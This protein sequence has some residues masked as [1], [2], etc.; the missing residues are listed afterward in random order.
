MKKKWST[1]Q[2]IG[3]SIGGAVLAMVLLMSF[4][5]SVYQLFDRITSL[6]TTRAQ[7]QE[8]EWD[9]E[10]DEDDLLP[11]DWWDQEEYYEFQ[12]DIKQD[13]SYSVTFEDF[14]YTSPENDNCEI[15]FSYPLVSGD[16]VPNIDGVN[17]AI[18]EELTVVQEYVDDNASGLLEEET[19]EFE[20]ECYVTYMEE[21]I[22]SIIYV[23]TGYY[24]NEA[25]EFY[26][27]SLNFDMETGMIMSNTQL[28]DIDDD[29]SIEFR[30][31][32]EKQN[33]EFD[34]ISMM[35]DQEITAYL[36]NSDQIII[37]YTPMGME[38]GFNYYEGW[39][40]VTYTDYLKFQQKL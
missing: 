5:I 12:D 23:E 33:G 19:F 18:Q 10:Q 7:S 34:T 29:F 9:E 37:F 6:K 38:V 36:S 27:V 31:R 39:V 14:H 16:N 13:L 11:E 17:A 20:G 40:T 30:K 35:S 26:V 8:E 2:I 3:L 28:L 25:Y 22:L 15:S 21:D 24:N 32:C 1:G 4:L